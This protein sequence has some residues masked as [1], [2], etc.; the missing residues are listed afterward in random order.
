MQSF[1]PQVVADGVD[2]GEV[3]ADPVGGVQGDRLA[4]PALVE[5][6]GTVAGCQH[7]GDRF[8]VVG[9]PGPAL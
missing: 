3:V 4:D 7:A 9:H 6:G 1:H 5:A 8:Q 2:V